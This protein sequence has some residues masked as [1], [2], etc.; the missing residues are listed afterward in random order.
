M[1]RD[2]ADETGHGSGSVLER[3]ARIFEES[4]IPYMIVGG[5]AAIAY[6]SQRAT[7]DVDIVV[8]VPLEGEAGVKA[9]LEKSGFD[10]E[11]PIETTPENLIGRRL[12]VRGA[13]I[14]IEVFL[15][16]KSPIVAKE[17]ERREMVTIGGSPYPAIAKEDLILRKIVLVEKVHGRKNREL[18]LMDLRAVMEINWQRLDFVYMRE[19][20]RLHRVS[21]QLEAYIE[22]I[23]RERTREGLPV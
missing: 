20:A 4:G 12:R 3:V 16:A 8:Q 9:A 18:D 5:W 23:R 11:G 2:Q 1:S 15:S 21:G 10:V 13:A 19:Q 22:E 7:F 14:P 6:G 17:F